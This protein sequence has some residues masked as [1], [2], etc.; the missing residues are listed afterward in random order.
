MRTLP[1]ALML[2][3]NRSSGYDPRNPLAALGV[4]ILEGLA[5][6][7]VTLLGSS[8]LSTLE[9]GVV[10]F[11]LYGLAFIGGWVEQIGKGE[12]PYGLLLRLDEP[13]PGIASLFARLKETG[14]DKR[15]LMMTFSEFGRRVQ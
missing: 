13:A 3:G 9:N 15:V 10:V 6:L 2:A 5:V 7:S 12:H 8:L 4:L 11:M 1:S 14:H